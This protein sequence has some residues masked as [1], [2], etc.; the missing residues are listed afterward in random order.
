MKKTGIAV[1]IFCLAMLSLK[2]FA[3]EDY[4]VISK[5]PVKSV[6]SSNPEVV[7]ANVLTTLMNE[8]DTVIVRSVG[9]GKA[10]LTFDFYGDKTDVLVDVKDKETKVKLKDSGILEFMNIDAPPELV[11]VP[12]SMKEREE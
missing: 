2:V 1:V 7:L 4:I 10:V 9:K 8:K 11:D 12:P 3:F 5:K 6:I